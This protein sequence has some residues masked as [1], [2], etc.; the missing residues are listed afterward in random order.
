MN[1]SSLI[2]IPT[3]N[4]KDN[5]ARMIP[6][7]FR[8]LPGTHILVVDDSSP[9]GTADVVL[10]LKNPSVFLLK[11]NGKQGLGTAYIA[12]F[13]WALER[14][15]RFIFEMDADFSHDPADLPRLL[16]ACTE[17]ADV[18]IGSRYVSG[19]NVINWPLGRIIMSYGASLYVRLITGLPVKDAT[20]GFKCYRR[21]VLETIDL[22]KVNSIGYAFQIE[23]KFLAWKYGFR[24]VE[25]PIIFRDRTAGVSKM[26]KKIFGEAMWGVIR[27][28]WNSLFKK[29]PRPKSQKT[30]TK[31]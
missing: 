23:M 15:Y 16:Q 26:S 20:A 21:A 6:A 11:R 4:E 10:S 19:V 12:G 1:T 22:D 24:V 30:T 29:Y 2:I 13:K 3:Y 25:V 9:D 28:K 8:S 31:A 18:A 17:G 27:M 7:I 5:I 14:D